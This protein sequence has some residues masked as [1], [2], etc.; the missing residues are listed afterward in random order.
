[1]YI[2]VGIIII[3]DSIVILGSIAKTTPIIYYGT[4]PITHIDYE[5]NN[6]IFATYLY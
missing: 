3:L 2:L 4:I 5:I 1:M 6:L